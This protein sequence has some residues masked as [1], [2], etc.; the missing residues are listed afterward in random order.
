MPKPKP[1]VKIHAAAFYFSHLSRDLEQIASVF[2]VS[3]DTVRNWSKTKAWQNALSVFGY[4]GARNF[5]RQPR[6][7]TKRD[8]GETFE[9]AKSVYLQAL[10]AGEPKHKL[11]TIAGAAV[12]LPRR[13]IHAWALKYGWRS[14]V[15]NDTEETTHE[16]DQTP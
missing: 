7:D 10:S 15:E 6:R 5:S 16:R 1:V 9:K 3:T 13:R 8:A 11:S 14:D 2:C 12:G 4:T